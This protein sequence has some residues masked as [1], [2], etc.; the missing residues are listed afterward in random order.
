MHIYIHMHIYMHIQIHIQIHM[1]MH[2]HMHI[3]MHIHIRI[4]MGRATRCFS[5]GAPRASAP[6]TTTSGSFTRPPCR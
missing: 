4:H 6:S 3:H 1:H 2:V 5:R